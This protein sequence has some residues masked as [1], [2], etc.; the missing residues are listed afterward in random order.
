ME[1]QKLARHLWHGLAD[2]S[3]SLQQVVDSLRGLGLINADEPRNALQLASLL[4]PQ[5]TAIKSAMPNLNR[6]VDGFLLADRL[7]TVDIT[8]SDDQVLHGSYLELYRENHRH[9]RDRLPPFYSGFSS[10][11]RLAGPRENDLPKCADRPS[12]G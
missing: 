9:N 6:A 8:I 3:I 5:F 1:L 12:S 11:I 4:R 7:S 10:P 2:P